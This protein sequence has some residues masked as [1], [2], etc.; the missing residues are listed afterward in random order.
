M[1]QTNEPSQTAINQQRQP[2]SESFIVGIVL[3]LS[4]FINS[5][6][7]VF[8]GLALFS[9]SAIVMGIVGTLLGLLLMSG[10]LLMF[11]IKDYP[12]KNVKRDRLR[13]RIFV[14]L[15]WCGY[16]FVVWSILCTFLVLGAAI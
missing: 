2:M 8:F 3:F 16:G 1:N 10:L 9:K 14:C 12:P 6:A 13:H 15:Q 7:I 5:L 4:A 11:N